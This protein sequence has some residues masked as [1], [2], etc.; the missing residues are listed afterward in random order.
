MCL[1]SIVADR[2]LRRVQYE[3]LEI[4]LRDEGIS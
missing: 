1:V 2:G 4:V 3:E